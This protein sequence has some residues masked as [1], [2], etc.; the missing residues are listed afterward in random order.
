ME[1]ID[2]RAVAPEAYGLFGKL[3]AY[4]RNCGLE[5][6][7]LEFV[8]LRASQIN[9]C[10]HCVNLHAGT[11]RKEGE[12]EERIQGAVAWWAASCFS[13]REQAAL[14]WTDAVTLVAESRVPDEVF[15]RA[16]AQFDEKE[17]V[18]LTAAICTINAHNRLA[19]AFRR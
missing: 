12:S 11:L 9:G 1:R 15:E 14:A 16:R 13:E 6:N 19:V 10:A 7:L 4:S 8:K 5:H 3:S 18:D 17:L 2:Y